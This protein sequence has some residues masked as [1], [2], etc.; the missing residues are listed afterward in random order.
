MKCFDVPLSVNTTGKGDFDAYM[1]VYAPSNGLEVS[2]NKNRPAVVIFPGGAYCITYDGEAEPIALKFAA[3]GAV[4]AVVWYSTKNKCKEK[5]V[6]FP[7]AMAEGLLAVGYIRAHAEELGVDP[8]NIATLGFSAGGHLCGCTGTMWNHEVM[9]PYLPGDRNLYRPN[10]MFLCY[11]VLT[12]KR[13]YHRGSYLALLGENNM[14]DEMLEM[15]SLENQIGEHTPP[16]FIWHTFSDPSVPVQGPLVF[17]KTLADHKIPCE[18]HI[19]PQGGH[20]LCL[21]NQVTSDEYPADRP[22]YASEWIDHAVAFLFNK[23][24]GQ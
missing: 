10:K 12:S 6:R 11:A 15:L 2:L 7:Q 3:A 5:M 14:T 8:T 23:T 22:H 4:A 17:A 1:T 13:P 19:Y 18:L 24:I 9:A 21:A 16:T 20:G